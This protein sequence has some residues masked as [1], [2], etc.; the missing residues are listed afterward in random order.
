MLSKPHVQGIII[1]G[2]VLWFFRRPHLKDYFTESDLEAAQCESLFPGTERN[3]C[4]SKTTVVSVF[5]FMDAQGN[6]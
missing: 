2:S 3:M 5:N 6:G 1:M 4:L